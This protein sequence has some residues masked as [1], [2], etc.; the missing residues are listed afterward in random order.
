MSSKYSEG[1][2]LLHLEVNVNKRKRAHRHRE[3]RQKL[4]TQI[5]GIKTLGEGQEVSPSAAQLRS[6]CI[7]NTRAQK[8]REKS[9]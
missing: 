1:Q 6:E 8:R 7:L 5:D 3:R 9:S 4:M 2:D